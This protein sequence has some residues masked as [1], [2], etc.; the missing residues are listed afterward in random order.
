MFDIQI[1]QIRIYTD[2]DKGEEI[3]GVQ[4]GLRY[5]NRARL[6]CS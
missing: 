5:H 3:E 2:I 6:I 1:A 4:E